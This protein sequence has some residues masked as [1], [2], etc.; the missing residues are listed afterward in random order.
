LFRLMRALES[1]GIFTQVSPRVLANTPSS[2]LL[3]RN[4]PG[5]QRAF[6]RAVLSTGFGQYDSWA[7]IMHSIQTGKPAVEKRYGMGPWEF[8]NSRPEVWAVFNEA[9][10]Y[11]LQLMAEPTESTEEHDKL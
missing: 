11:A 4:V 6:V 10:R 2:E 5:S 1:V 8:F 9:M 3:R 7:E